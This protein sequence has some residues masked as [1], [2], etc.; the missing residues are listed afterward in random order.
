MIIDCLIEPSEIVIEQLDKESTIYDELS[1]EPIKQVRRKTRVT[2]E[3]QVSWTRNQ[4]V[5]FHEGGQGGAQ[6]EATGYLV[7]MRR[8]V[9][10][11]GVTLQRGDRIVSIAGINLT[12]LTFLTGEQRAGH[13]ANNPNLAIWDMS[14]RRPTN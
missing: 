7:F 14:D 3:A 4:R 8:D 9:E 10:D 6:N 12:P 11:A 2:L 5:G 1:R 13:L